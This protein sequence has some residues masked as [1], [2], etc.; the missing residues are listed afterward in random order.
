MN[1]TFSNFNLPVT[2]LEA[3]FSNIKISFT[4]D[5]QSLNKYYLTCR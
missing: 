1:I 3:T 5:L 4:T 2:C